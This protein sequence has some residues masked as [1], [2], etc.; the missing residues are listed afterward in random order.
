MTT[1]KLP[2]YTT[3]AEAANP[4]VGVIALFWCD[5]LG[6][7]IGRWVFGASENAWTSAYISGIVIAVFVSSMVNRKPPIENL[8]I[9]QYPL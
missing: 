6:C 1:M 9:R 3:L 8:F 7:K 5:S 4:V 2:P